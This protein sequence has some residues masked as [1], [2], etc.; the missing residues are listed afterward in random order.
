MQLVTPWSVTLLEMAVLGV[1]RS[2]CFA[3]IDDIGTLH[4]IKSGFKT[5]RLSPERLIVTSKMDNGLADMSLL[6]KED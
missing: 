3:V 5:G 2:R 4:A 1:L 6:D